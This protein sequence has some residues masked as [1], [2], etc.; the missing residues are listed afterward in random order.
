MGVRY[1]RTPGALGIRTTRHTVPGPGIE[2]V[3]TVCPPYV[4]LLNNNNS[5]F[6]WYEASLKFTKVVLVSTF[7]LRSSLS[8]QK[9]ALYSHL[10]LS[11]VL[12]HCELS[13]YIRL[14]TRSHRHRRSGHVTSPTLAHSRY[15]TAPAR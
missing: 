8:V 4:V 12:S 5:L 1:S 7:A 14:S 2:L 11:L 3:G 10:Y 6:P 13:H 15:G 9:K